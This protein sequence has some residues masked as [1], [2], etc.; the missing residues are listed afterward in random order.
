M[1]NN[2][3]GTSNLELS[4]VANSAIRFLGKI[5]TVKSGD[6]NAVEP[7]D[8]WSCTCNSYGRDR[9]NY[10]CMYHLP[11]LCCHC[12]VDS[13]KVKVVRA[14]VGSLMTSLEMAGVSLTLLR[15]NPK[16]EQHLGK[17]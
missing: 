15:V 3:G 5:A 17:S 4:I 2:L 6:G 16:W 14:Y 8:G 11:P 9:D 12:T 13:M 10:V 1:V 7:F